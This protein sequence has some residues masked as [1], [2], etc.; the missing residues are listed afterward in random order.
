M[1]IIFHTPIS[2]YTKYCTI[3]TYFANPQM[4]SVLRGT[5]HTHIK[6]VGNMPKMLKAFAFFL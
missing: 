2:L 1:Y 4:L 5:V 6:V 3:S